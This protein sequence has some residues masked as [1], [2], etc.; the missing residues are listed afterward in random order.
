MG[1]STN[2][3]A[4]RRVLILAAV[5]AV[6]V[7][8]V[9]PASAKDERVEGSFR[10]TRVGVAECPPPGICT[11]GSSFGDI[12]STFTLTGT[13]APSPNFASTGVVTYTATVV[14]QTRRGTFTC[15]DT[16]VTKVTLPGAASSI[17]V[18]QPALG[19]GIWA[20]ATGYVQ[21]QATLT[22]PSTF[23]GTYQGRISFPAD[24]DDDHDD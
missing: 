7:T 18:L 8:G 19:T 17:C 15:L 11:T 6:F 4:R 3:R 21:F 24:D 12:R 20:G 16:G 2:Q 23:R 22:P 5:V 10:S 9:L 13:G 14:L 1:G